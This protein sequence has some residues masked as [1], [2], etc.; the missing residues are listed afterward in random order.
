[1][2]PEYQKLASQGRK[3]LGEQLGIDPEEIRRTRAI[4]QYQNVGLPT[5]RAAAEKAKRLSA[6]EALD[7]QTAERERAN[8]LTEALLGA[9]GST[10]Q[11][12][13]G[14]AGRAGLG[15]ERRAAETQRQRLVEANT[16]KDALA[17]I[18]I[19]VKTG[20]YGAGIAALKEAEGRQDKAL[21]EA[22]LATGRAMSAETS[23]L[24]NEATNR[25]NQLYHQAQML[26]AKTQNEGL[27]QA[28][29]E[30]ARAQT[31]RAVIAPLQTALTKMQSD[32]N[33]ISGGKLTPQQ[34][35]DIKAL[36]KTIELKTTEIQDRFEKLMIGS[37]AGADTGFQV[38]RIK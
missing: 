24:T 7:A 26:A 12:A 14:S 10:W 34:A 16:A 30:S 36:E 5:E 6:L 13:L 8:Q 31:Y 32:Y 29:L 21:T 33:V 2:P 22:G 3:V 25:A 27:R 1:V 28:R 19:G 9:R 18:G 20:S 38:E 23:R 35:Q 11:Q 17:D 37:D 15:A 4:E